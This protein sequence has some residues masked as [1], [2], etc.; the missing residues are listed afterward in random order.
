MDH[1]PSPKNGLTSEKAFVPYVCKKHYD[2]GPFLTYP[3]REC[4]T[5]A[6]PL[7]GRNPGGSPYWNHEQKYPTPK[8]EKED[9]L[10]RWLFFGLIHEILGDRY[11]PEDLI[12]TIKTDEGEKSIVSTLGLV[13]TLD[14]WISDIRGSINLRHTYEHIAECLCLTFATLHGARSDI[15]P[16]VKLSLASLGELFALATNEAYHPREDKCPSIFHFLV[17][18]AYWK[19]PML[20]SGWCP[21]QIKVNSENNFRLSTLRFLTLLGQP[22]DDG[23]HER[24]NSDRCLAYQND[25]AS[26]QTKH[27]TGCNCE[28]FLIDTKYL[29][30][31][32]ETGSL[33]L[34]RIQTGNVLS[35]LSVEIVPSQSTSCY[36]ALSH[37]WA[38]GLGNPVQNSLPRCQLE[39]LHKTIEEYNKKLNSGADQEMLLWID[40]LCCPVEP[41]NAKNIALASMKKTYLEATR[42]LVLDTLLRTHCS[43][44]MDPVEACIRIVNSGWTRRLW[45]LQEGALPARNSRLSFLFRDGAMNIHHLLQLMFQTLRSSIGMKGLVSNIINRIGNFASFPIEY[46][47][48]LREDL[49][50]LEIS[51]RHRSVSVPCDEP[52]LIANLLDLGIDNILKGSCPIANCANVGCDH[53]RIHRMWSLMPAAFRGIPR[54]IVLHVG[55]RLSEPG[56][57]W[58]P[59]TLLYHEPQN[60]LLWQRT[61]ERQ[62]DTS[63]NSESLTYPERTMGLMIDYTSRGIPTDRGLLVG[64][65]GYSLSTAPGVISNPWNVL[66]QEGSMYLRD[67]NGTWFQINRRLPAEK[68][69]FFSAKSFHEI[70]QEEGNLW[71]MYEIISQANGSRPVQIGLLVQLLSDEGGIKYVQSKLHIGIVPLA[72]PMQK[73]FEAAYESAK[74]VTRTLSMS[75]LAVKSDG[76]S[77]AS[78]AVD[79]TMPE[80]RTHDDEN[81]L[82]EV[83]SSMLEHEIELVAMQNASQD[84]RALAD[85]LSTDGD[86]IRL[87]KEIIAK[88][89][90]GG[91]GNLGPSTRKEQQWCCD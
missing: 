38:D 18:G 2:F 72:D 75:R 55:P 35:E 36:I 80:E 65:T 5:H 49:G 57:R 27:I 7:D 67:I 25:L 48:D 30:E 71:I 40:T 59:S 56:F 6:L 19:Q 28:Q 32:L 77:K 42:V 46:E 85:T 11:K 8:A 74:E 43:K 41:G 90:V 45:T 54:T 52:L 3:V 70:V 29:T 17:D 64:F 91:Y 47:G 68:D 31:I 81:I 61:S 78:G 20:A 14:Q 82:Y 50:T 86:G 34:L 83:E 21:C 73:L 87:F 58:A 26:Y 10:Q 51:L 33:P 63:S 89:V 1:L 4:V 69:S 53:S 79:S 44:T 24:C 12:R 13:E 60:L 16:M 22:A 15:D 39:F 88:W 62:E 76:E 84:I 37:V 23:L 66:R 9:F